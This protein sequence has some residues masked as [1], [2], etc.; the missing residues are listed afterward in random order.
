MINYDYYVFTQDTFILENKYDFNKLKYLNVQACSIVEHLEHFI[1]YCPMEKLDILQKHNIS[2]NNTNICWGC[3]FVIS[4]NKIFNLYEYIKE[5]ILKTK[6]HS[7]LFERIMGFFIKEL[8]PKNC[9][10]DGFMIDYE[11]KNRLHYFEKKRQTKYDIII[12]STDIPILKNNII[13]IKNI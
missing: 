4:K 1:W 6:D 8:E 13:T 5:H 7:C 11:T 12:E 3:N 2:F 9:N 10:I